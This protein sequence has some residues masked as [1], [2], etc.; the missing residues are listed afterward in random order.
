MKNN[1]FYP[2]PLANI[3]ATANVRSETSTQILYGEKFKILKK[4][5]NWVKIKTSYDNYIGFLKYQKFKKK[6]NPTHKIFKLKSQIFKKVKNKFIPSGKYLFFT[7]KIYMLSEN[8]KF[9]EFEKNEWIK[10]ND[11]KPIN[12]HEKNFSKLLKLFL[13]TKYLWGGKTIK[14]IDCSALVQIYFLF[15]NIYFPRDTKDQIKF[16]R[17]VKNHK[18]YKKNIFL[19]WKGHVAVSLNRIFLIHAYGPKKKVV[20]M[21]KNKTIKEIKKNTNLTLLSI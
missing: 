21:K 11:I 10:K 6:F 5:N 2:K 12:Y 17:K 15:N 13:G 1:Y 20:I 18:L 16:L 19:Y 4:N 9:I 14:G 8:K 3:Y 7:S